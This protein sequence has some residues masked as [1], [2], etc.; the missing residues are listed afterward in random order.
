MAQVAPGFEISNFVF[1]KSVGSGAFAS[2]WR[3]HHKVSGHRVAIKVIQKAGITSEVAHTRLEREKA[4]LKKMEHPFVAEFFQFMEDDHSVFLVM[5]YVENGNLLD[6]VNTNGRLAEDQARRY[7]AQLVSVLEY[8]HSELKVAHRDLKCENVLLDR[9][10]NIRVIDFG[11]S[12][13]FNDINPVLRTACGSPAYAAPEMVKGNPYTP[14]ADIWSAGILLFAIVAGYLPFDDDNIQR[15]LQKIVYTEA[16]YPAFM[17][18]Q[19]TDLLQKMICKDPQRRITLDMIKNHPWF[20]QSEYIAL[21]EQSRVETKWDG[22]NTDSIIAKEIIDEITRLGIGCH[23]LHHSLLVGDFT[24]LTALYRI[25]F[26]QRMME[27]MKDIMTKVVRQAGTRKMPLPLGRPVTPGVSPRGTPAPG[28][29][30]PKPTPF[31]AAGAAPQRVL[32]TPVAVNTSARRGSRPVA[33]RPNIAVPS[34]RGGAA[35]AHET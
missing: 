32:T 23:E 7:F 22:Q 29:G 8:L 3:A 24:E 11:L 33:V 20:S 35:P 4:F 10:N 31:P 6:Y 25:I 16:R 14:A 19:L 15:L 30:A 34:P 18:P 12:N 13:Q 26:R 27:K 5:E 2:V 9:Y 1:E 21:L 17:T 28:Y